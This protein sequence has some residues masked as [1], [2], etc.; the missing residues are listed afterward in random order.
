MQTT[1]QTIEDWLGI[2]EAKEEYRALLNILEDFEEEKIKF[3]QIQKAILNLLDDMIE[4]RIKSEQTKQALMNILED[5]ETERQKIEK[6]KVLLELANKELE[7]FSYSVSHDL[8]APLRAINGFAQAVVEDYSDKLDEEGQRYIK[9]IQKNSRFMGQLIQDLLAFS[10]LGRQQIGTT[11]IDMERLA[12]DVFEELKGEASNRVIEFKL[13]SL[14]KAWCDPTMAHQ[15]FVNLLS[16]ALKFT[17][18]REKAVIEIGYLQKENEGYYY[19]K[20]NGAGFDMKYVDKLFGVFQRLHTYEEF[21]GTGIGLALVKRIVTKHGGRI[22]AE[23][24]INEGACFYFTLSRGE[25]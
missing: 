18:H 4:E 22:W 17:G 13:G 24:N 6:S 16:N 19:I 23:G 10:R 12:K 1:F 7:A 14:P 8:Q 3:Q 2:E 25:K 9:L 15:I 11:E 5:I 21:E 20:D